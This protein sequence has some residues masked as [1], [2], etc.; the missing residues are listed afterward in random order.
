MNLGL[1]REEWEKNE[2]NYGHTIYTYLHSTKPLEVVTYQ[3]SDGEGHGWV[4]WQVPREWMELWFSSSKVF[5]LVD[6]WKSLIRCKYVGTEKIGDL[7]PKIVGAF[8]QRQLPSKALEYP[9]RLWKGSE[10]LAE[11]YEAWMVAKSHKCFGIDYDKEIYQKGL[12][13][14]K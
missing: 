8:K 10:F 2:D 9:S 13:A 7:V 1:K 6:G 14:F 3:T 12:E 4:E 5:F 11:H